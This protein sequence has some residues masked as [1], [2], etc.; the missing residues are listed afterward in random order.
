[1]GGFHMKTLERYVELSLPVSTC[2]RIY[3]AVK[4]Q[5]LGACL[6]DISPRGSGHV[7][8]SFDGV[9]WCRHSSGMRLRP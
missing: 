2:L 9:V 6:Y 1:M 3:F 5:K 8:S 4:I 7:K